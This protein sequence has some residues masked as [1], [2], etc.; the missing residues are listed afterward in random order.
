MST[1]SKPSSDRADK[2][3]AQWLSVARE[4]R[5]FLHV[6]LPRTVLHPPDQV[7]SVARGPCRHAASSRRFELG[8]TSS[9]RPGST[10]A[11]SWWGVVGK[12]V[13]DKCAWAQLERHASGKA[14]SVAWGSALGQHTD[15][16]PMAALMGVDD[17]LREAAGLRHSRAGHVSQMRRGQR[18]MK[19]RSP[20]RRA[21]SA[22][23][24][25]TS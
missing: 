20:R 21:A 12:G 4:I 18:G 25:S 6:G 5:T 23:H 9:A 11:W 7:S 8:P 14:R 2:A 22:P 24:S 16:A 3:A 10:N 17:V 19:P 13:W 15:G 1:A